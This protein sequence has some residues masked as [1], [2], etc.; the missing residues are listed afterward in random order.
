MTTLQDIIKLCTA[1]DG[2]V[3]VVNEAGDVRFVLM[4]LEG[5]EK[6]VRPQPK[7]TAIDPEVINKKILHA[8]LEEEPAPIE[9]PPPAPRAVPPRATISQNDLREEVIDPSFNFDIP[10]DDLD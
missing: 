6:L 9:V 10:A 8:Q 4:N 1:E 7:K 5:Y 3:F 2:K